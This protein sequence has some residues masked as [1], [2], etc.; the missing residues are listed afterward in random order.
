[1]Y[2]DTLQ[3]LKNILN[4]TKEGMSMLQLKYHEDVDNLGT[5]QKRKCLVTEHFH[6]KEL[7]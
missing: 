6:R 2:S 5:C 1:M 7:D 4:S 3:E